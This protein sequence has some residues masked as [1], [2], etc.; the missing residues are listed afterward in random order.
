MRG[1]MVSIGRLT[2]TLKRFLIAIPE[3]QELVM[4][5]ELEELRHCHIDLRDD[6]IHI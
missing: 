2:E 6:R 3:V 5:S 1:R 4:H